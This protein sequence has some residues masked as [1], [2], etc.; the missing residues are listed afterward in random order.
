MPN[1]HPR[2]WHRG[3]VFGNGPR[4][5]LEREQ[6]ARFK[7]LLNAHRRARRLTPHAELVGAALLRRLS[8]DGRCDPSHD[9]ISQDVGCGARTVR[10]AL[11]ALKA[12][13]L[14]MWQCRLVRDGW[15]C[16]QTSN[17]Y[18]LVPGA[19][20]LAAAACDGQSGRE[21]RPLY[22]KGLSFLSNVKSAQEG[23]AAIALRRLRALGL[24]R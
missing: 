20:T 16:A 15:R 5:P 7:Y 24:G 11:A 6:R 10:R 3:S 14:L 18:V 17:S 21:T 23:L 1:P 19:G 9:R 4:R 8:V 2:P 22:N 12:L 13:G